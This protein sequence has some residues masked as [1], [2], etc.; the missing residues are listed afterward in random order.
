MAARSLAPTAKQLGI[1]AS[2]LQAKTTECDANLRAFFSGMTSIGHPIAEQR[3][4]ELR[5]SVQNLSEL[6]A[7]VTSMSELLSMMKMAAVM[8]VS[9][10][11]ALRPGIAGAEAVQVSV[12]TVQ[13]WTR[14]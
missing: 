1:E 9:L 5:A 7:T 6:E 13:S 4:T 14:L 12:R 10:R 3:L 11:R 8:N 2:D